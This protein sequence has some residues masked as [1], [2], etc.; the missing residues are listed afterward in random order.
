MTFTEVTESA[1]KHADLRLASSDAPS[2]AWA[3]FPRPRQKAATRGSTNRPVTT[4]RPA[5]GTTPYVTFLHETG[6]ALGLEHAHEGNVMPVNRDS[7]EYTVMSYRSYVGAST[8]TGYTN[9]TW[10]YAQSLMMYISPPCSICTARISPPKAETRPI[11]EPD[12]GR[13]VYQW[14]RARCPCGN[15]I[16]LTV[17]DGGGTEHYDFSNYTT[18]LKVI[19]AGRMDDTS[20][21]QLAKLHYKVQGGDRQYCHALQFQGDARSLIENAKGGTG[22]GH[23]H[24]A[25]PLQIF[26]VTAATTG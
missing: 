18:A 20:A 21:A 14:C 3:Y 12:V 7:M 16:L 25:M 13:D 6:H 24:P 26:G 4:S 19:C 11:A 22:S 9:E 5:K 10:G 8:T 15:K 1:N 2:T 23:D 17:W